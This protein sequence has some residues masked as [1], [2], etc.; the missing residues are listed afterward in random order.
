MED[1]FYYK[2]IRLVY[3]LINLLILLMI[4]AHIYILIVEEN[5]MN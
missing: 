1:C 3:E 2:I 4:F 5:L